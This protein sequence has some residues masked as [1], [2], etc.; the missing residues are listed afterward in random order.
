MC[1]KPTTIPCNVYEIVLN[2]EVKSPSVAVNFPTE[3]P[4][5]KI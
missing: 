3:V 4:A 2:A 5:N 1:N